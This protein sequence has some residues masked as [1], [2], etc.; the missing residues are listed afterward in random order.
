MTKKEIDKIAGFCK[1][2]VNDEEEQVLNDLGRKLDL[3]WNRIMIRGLRMVQLVDEGLAE[4]KLVDKGL[5]LEDPL[6]V[7]DDWR[8]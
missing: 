7:N 1:V 2:Y 5:K 3:S 8:K 6:G 4:L